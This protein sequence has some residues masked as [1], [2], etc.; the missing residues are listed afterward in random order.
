L[1]DCFAQADKIASEKL[2]KL[3]VQFE[4]SE[5]AFFNEFW[6]ARRIGPTGS[7]SSSDKQFGA[8]VAEGGL[9]ASFGKVAAVRLRVGGALV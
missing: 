4:A 2:E 6:S 8:A 5:P 7:R 9:T 3:V 1:R